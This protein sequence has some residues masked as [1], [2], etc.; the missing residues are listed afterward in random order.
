MI[1]TTIEKFLSE[2]REALLS[3]ELL[4]HF[5]YTREEM[6]DFIDEAR[7]YDIMKS[8]IIHGSYRAETVVDMLKAV[9]D[10][11]CDE[12]EGGWVKF[13]CD[14]TVARLYPDNFT[15]RG[16][17]MQHKA[18]YFI[19]E[20]YRCI[21]K[22]EKSLR[23]LSPVDDFML[24]DEDE[25]E[26]SHNS[27]EYRTFLKF[28]D[29]YYIY[30][31]MR[32]NREIT[33]FNTL[34]HIAGVHHVA[35]YM[36][37]QLARK[38]V[39]V[40]LGLMSGAALMHDM[41]KYGCRPQEGRRVPYLHYYY[42]FQYCRNNHL[43]TIGDIAAN[44]SVWDLE[45]ENLSAESL[46]L[47]YADFRVKS[48]YDENRKEHI[49]FWS[50]DD[51]YEVILGNLDNVDEAKKTRYARVYAKLKDFEDYML[52]LGCAVDLVSSSGTPAQEAY[53]SVMQPEEMVWRFKHLAIRSNLAI[54]HMISREEQFISILE[55]IR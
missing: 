3:K 51:A 4:Q 53:A 10:N 8:I 12:P 23:S 25:I 17:E 34:G 41:G 40:D 32:M 31:F 54:M 37:R 30:E 28:W 35:M 19:L 44:H 16:S 5:N 39:P 45:L 6:S 13:I 33:P 24:C 52:S 50:L 46:L 43:E 27:I 20:N 38:N 1:N 22:F 36:A 11:I 26:S 7:W 42:T 55:N 9:T 15:E 18:M 29:E 48:V 14:E 47:I 2:S 21:L 49:R